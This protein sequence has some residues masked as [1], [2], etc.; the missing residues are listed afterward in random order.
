MHN[1]ELVPGNHTY[2]LL[3]DFD[4]QMDHLIL[5]RRPDLIIINKTKRTSKIVDFA[6]SVDHSKIERKWKEG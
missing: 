3:W 6:A 5:A 4:V 2:K 1:L